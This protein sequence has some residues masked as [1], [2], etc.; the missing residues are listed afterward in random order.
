MVHCL[1]H[2]T[3]ELGT[4]S[5]S[6]WRHFEH[7]ADIGVE[8]TGAS[9]AEAFE[10][11]AT[12]LTAVVADPVS[13]RAERRYMVTCDEP[14]PEFLFVDWLNALIYRMATERMLFSRFAVR[15]S[16][17]RLRAE[18]W[19]EPVDPVRHRPAVEIKGAT[20]TGLS[21]ARR[22]D[23]SWCARCVVDV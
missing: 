7:R 17:A 3:P 12:A 16:G 18:I 1:L 14:D 22:A 6:G 15:I 2:P 19:G 4:A 20:Y 21:V 11:A 23:G 5:P 9:L 8:G 10:Q 13:V